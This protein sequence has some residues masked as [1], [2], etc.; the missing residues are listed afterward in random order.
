VSRRILN[1]RDFLSRIGAASAG[2]ALLPFVPMLHREVE[3]AGAEVPKRLLFYMT[4]NGTFWDQLVPSGGTENSFQLGPILKPL[5]EFKKKLTIIEGCDLSPGNAGR[6]HN[7]MVAHARANHLLTGRDGAMNGYTNANGGGISVDQVIAQRIG[8]GT[9]ISSVELGCWAYNPYSFSGVNQPRSGEIDPR[10]VYARL[11]QGGGGATPDSGVGVK[12]G[13]GRS[14]ERR[15]VLDVVREHLRTI[16]R[17]ATYEERMK[18]QAHLSAVE[19]LGSQLDALD[20]RI[21]EEAGGTCRRPPSPND[22]VTDTGVKQ[23][24]LYPTILPI[25]LQLLASALA[26]DVTRV[27]SLV[28]GSVGNVG[29]TVTWVGTGAWNMHL[30]SHSH[31]RSQIIPLETWY[32]TQFR[33]LLRFMDSIKEG[34]RTLLDNS[35]VIWVKSMSDG[36]HRPSGGR[37]SCGGTARCSSGWANFPIVMAGSAGGKIRTGRYLYNRSGVPHQRWLVSL[38][39]AFGLSDMNSFGDPRYNNGPLPGLV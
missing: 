8:K 29:L 12:P 4:P 20:E 17:E 21:A 6:P 7:N 22:K 33:D 31:V 16:E 34:D 14:A 36:G 19:T 18:F 5:E 37:G 11:F 39:H 25:Q 9:P 38:L 23:G 2:G 3:A 28:G 10:K 32:A 24:S 13:P 26:C 27:A 30:T 15:R 1:R 35:L